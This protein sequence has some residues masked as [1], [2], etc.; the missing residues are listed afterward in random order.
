MDHD[1]RAAERRW[2]AD[3]ADIEARQRAVAARRRAGR[4][5]WAWMEE[6]PGA[7]PG[8]TVDWPEP[9][10]VLYVRPDG[11]TALVG[12]TPGAV[13]VPGNRVW[14]LYPGGSHALE[15]LRAAERLGAPEL[16]VEG[17]HLGARDL[18]VLE[19]LTGLRLLRLR[20]IQGL[21][22]GALA[23]LGRLRALEEL[24]LT[25][26]A[27]LADGDLEALAGLPGPADAA[28]RRL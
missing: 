24:D 8:P 3:P 18:A 20:A 28:D 23:V 14:L 12:R 9:L 27:A 4:R 10:Q 13:D 26:T 17:R 25:G 7:A 11:T 2:R 5:V 6:D 15:A 1:G 22:R 21:A 16:W 19:R